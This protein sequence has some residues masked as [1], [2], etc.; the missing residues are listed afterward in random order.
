LKS[1][2]GSW[3]YKAIMRKIFFRSIVILALALGVPGLA[4]CE[5]DVRVQ[6]LP[7]LTFAHLGAIEL[8]V[9]RLDV[10]SRYQAPMKRPNVDHLFPVS[11]LTAMKRWAQDRIKPAGRSGTVTFTV[12]EASVIEE[13]LKMKSGVTG[14]FTTQQSERYTARVEATLEVVDQA[15]QRRGFA[16]ANAVRSR[17]LREDAS[18]NAR[19]KMWF[20]LV[21]ELMQEFD[22][23]MTKNIK[24]HLV[25]WI[26]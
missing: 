24:T 8:N 4:G 6:K 17:T 19:E 9:A 16:T 10:V 23:E 3:Q 13:K 22:K 25:N 21:E 12:H 26:M 14:T 5:T 11:P 7:E 18:L 1:G 20:G 2:G 15:G